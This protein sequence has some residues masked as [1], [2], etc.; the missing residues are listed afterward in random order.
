MTSMELFVESIQQIDPTGQGNFD[1]SFSHL[2]ETYHNL[3]STE[4]FKSVFVVMTG[5][6]I[7]NLAT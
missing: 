5:G 1:G 7:R 3:P 4:N 6:R 2:V